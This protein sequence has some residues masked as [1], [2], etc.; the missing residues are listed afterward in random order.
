MLQLVLDALDGLLQGRARRHVV[1]V[2]VDLHELQVVGLLAG[3][4]IELDDRLDLV[5]EEAD[6]PG[7][8]LQV[9]RKEFDHIAAHPKRAA[10]EIALDALVLQGHEVRDEL[11]L[12]DLLADL[13]GEGHG[14]IG[15]DRADTVDAR[16]GGDDDH[17]VA[18]QKRAGRRVAH[19]VDLLVDRAFLLDEGVRARHIG[20]GLVVVVIRD[21]VLD[22]VV[23]EERLE[24]AV[25]LGGERLVGREDE[26]R[27]LRLLD[28]LG[29]GEGL[30]RAGDAEQHLVALGAAHAVHQLADRGRLVA[31]GR[32]VGLDPE[33]NAAFRF[34]RA[35]RAV[36]HP[37]LAVLEARIALGEEARQ[38][39]DR[40]RDA[41]AGREVAKL[42]GHVRPVVGPFE[43][44]LL[45]QSRVDIGDIAVDEGFLRAL[46][47][48][49]G[50]LPLPVDGG[51]QEI[52][53]I[54]IQRL[55]LRLGGFPG[56]KL[57]L[58]G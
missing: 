31:G 40:G 32:E 22:R 4:R 16:H 21:E 18:L 34:L 10:G 56:G 42:L 50:R 39:I 17:V 57:G 14:G 23:R 19:A 2:R 45:G 8:V 27:A 1:R 46:G 25:E 29:H 9:G 35:R 49:L 37:G 7:A 3:E 26:G 48:A 55:E 13:H 58:L 33:W 36:R 6:A 24:L 43:A 41:G 44:E 52:G 20:F 51:I 15:L 30:A 47:K 12:L 11:A 28:H 38:R 5:A 54:G 53:Q